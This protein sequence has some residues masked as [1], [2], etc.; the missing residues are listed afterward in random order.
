M[1]RWIRK[2]FEVPLKKEKFRAKSPAVVKYPMLDVMQVLMT[3]Y[4]IS[5]RH[6]TS[7]NQLPEKTKSHQ[8]VP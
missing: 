5:P 7:A 2:M 6:F 1:M 8:K 4:E 3:Q